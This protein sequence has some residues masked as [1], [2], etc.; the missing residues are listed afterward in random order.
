MFYPPR[1]QMGR[2]ELDFRCTLDPLPGLFLLALLDHPHP[3]RVRSHLLHL[4]FQSSKQQHKIIRHH[5]LRQ[6]TTI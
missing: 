6:T 3:H 5:L 1:L 2:V 4:R